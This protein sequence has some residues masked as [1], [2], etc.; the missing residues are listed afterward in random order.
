M[1]I[2][3]PR[4]KNKG[5]SAGE[6]EVARAHAHNERKQLGTHAIQQTEAAQLSGSHFYKTLALSRLDSS[7]NPPL[8]PLPVDNL[9]TLF[10]AAGNTTNPPAQ[11]GDSPTI[12]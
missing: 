6:T 2:G 12:H 4:I 11:H 1:A 5:K 9:P 8:P 3:V 10:T 7:T